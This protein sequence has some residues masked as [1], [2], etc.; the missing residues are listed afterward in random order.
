[1]NSGLSYHVVHHVVPCRVRK[2]EKHVH[3]SRG[4][5]AESLT[6]SPRVNGTR[7]REFS[8]VNEMKWLRVSEVVKGNT[9][10]FHYERSLQLECLLDSR[11]F[12][13]KSFDLK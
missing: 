3:S 8:R 12:L 4:W 10:Q 5:G 9:F 7:A 2:L 13:C 11:V 6:L 1:M